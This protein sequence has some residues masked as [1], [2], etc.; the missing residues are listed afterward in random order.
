MLIQCVY[1]D[2]TYQ[3]DA[4][5][6]ISAWKAVAGAI[7]DV[8]PD[9]KMFW[10]REHLLPFSPIIN[11]TQIC[12]ITANIENDSAYAK[13]WPGA[14]Y[15][16]VV[17]I[18]YYPSSTG[19][20]VSKMQNFHDTYAVDGVKFAIGETGLGKSADI[21][22]RLAY[23]EE[24]TS[25]STKSA[26]PNYVGCS[27]FNVSLAMHSYRAYTNHPFMTVLQRSEQFTP[28]AL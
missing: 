14:D 23:V 4:S 3:G 13:Y 21:A 5:G 2:G 18:D 22:T 24:L 11:R 15:V 17:G 25:D 16:D 27:W 7:K 28:F 26:L 20:F 1:R 12:M 8:A 19:T 10:T 9:V 6:F